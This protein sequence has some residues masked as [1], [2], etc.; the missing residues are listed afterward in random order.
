[1]PKT[2]LFELIWQKLAYYLQNNI[3]DSQT[4]LFPCKN[5]VYLT[6]YVHLNTHK[7]S[8]DVFYLFWFCSLGRRDQ[9]TNLDLPIQSAI[10]THNDLS[11]QR[12]DTAK[13]L[14]RN[15]LSR[16]FM[17]WSYKDGWVHNQQNVQK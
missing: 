9:D 16:A 14:I 17:F 5:I 6:R 15:R 11:N 4:G 12:S 3:P 13:H 10:S 1:M 8:R 7:T 2:V